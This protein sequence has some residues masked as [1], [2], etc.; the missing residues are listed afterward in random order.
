MIPVRYYPLI[1]S[2]NATVA[3][4]LKLWIARD[5]KIGAER[6][7]LKPD[8]G[9]ASVERNHAPVAALLNVAH[10]PQREAE[11]ASYESFHYRARFAMRYGGHCTSILELVQYSCHETPTDSSLF[12]VGMVSSCWI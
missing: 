1:P 6:K 4:H 12:P 10:C 2:F 11:D 8:G 9:F 5:V 7:Y 3:I